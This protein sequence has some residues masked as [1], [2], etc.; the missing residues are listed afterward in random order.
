M[1]DAPCPL[2]SAPSP[3]LLP[4][5]PSLLAVNGCFCA[6]G[7]ACIETRRRRVRGARSLVAVGGALGSAAVE[8]R[9][10]LSSVPECSRPSRLAFSRADRAARE[11]GPAAESLRARSEAA[12]FPHSP[13]P[14]FIWSSPTRLASL[15]RGT[16]RMDG[17]LDQVVQV[18]P[19]SSLAA[20]NPSQRRADPAP[21][22]L[23]DRR[24][25][26]STR[27]RHRLTSRRPSSSSSSTSKPH[28]PPGRSSARSCRT[29][30]RASASSPRRPSSTSSRASGNRSQGSTPPSRSR[31]MDSPATSPPSRTRS[32]PGSRRAPPPP[33]RHPDPA[34]PHLHRAS[35]P[36]CA[37]SPQQ[38][39]R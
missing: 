23:V 5:R 3:P 38:R 27:P 4:A 14:R 28:P 2:L 1:T 13:P 6:F 11:Q 35:A 10:R 39:R 18:R 30:T 16:L 36:S 22:P 17:E 33:I 12:S 26:N 19:R 15:A 7:R 34:H 8:T 24:C 25:C 29:R 37:S 20:T 9:R 32:S 21:L 31:T